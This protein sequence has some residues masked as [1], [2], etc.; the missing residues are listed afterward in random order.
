MF[1]LLNSLSRSLGWI[2]RVQSCAGADQFLL[3]SVTV[4]MK[5]FYWLG[6]LFGFLEDDVRRSGGSSRDVD[7]AITVVCSAMA[8][9]RDLGWGGALI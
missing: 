3:A 4:P 1:C 8:I 6:R 9:F 2:E 5:P 7:I